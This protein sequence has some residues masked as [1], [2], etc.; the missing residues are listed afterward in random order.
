[1]ELLENDLMV[2]TLEEEMD[3]AKAVF[4]LLAERAFNGEDRDFLETVIWN[5]KCRYCRLITIDEFCMVL[6]I[7]QRWSERKWFPVHRMKVFDDPS[8]VEIK[9]SLFQDAHT[10]EEFRRA[11]LIILESW[12]YVWESYRGKLA[13][14]S[15]IYKNFIGDREYEERHM[16]HN[17]DSY[18]KEAE[19]I[20]I[21][22]W[23]EVHKVM[24]QHKVSQKE[25]YTFVLDYQKRGRDSIPLAIM[26]NWIEVESVLPEVIK[27]AEHPEEDWVDEGLSYSRRKQS[28]I[29][30]LRYVKQ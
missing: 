23:E 11:F 21:A 7:I 2:F 26:K 5:Q 25:A 28:V 24:G 18:L 27:G 3:Q 22:F 10:A 20:E 15:D 17:P 30:K 6:E 12:K 9:G 13:G 29:S 8:V 16:I 4:G 19:R 1:M 14:I